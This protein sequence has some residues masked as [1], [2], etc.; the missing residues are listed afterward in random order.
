MR[1][2]KNCFLLKNFMIKILKK[3]F[4]KKFFTFHSKVI[5]LFCGISRCSVPSHIKMLY[6]EQYY[7]DYPQHQDQFF[8]F[9]SNTQ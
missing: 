6:G 2:L 7:P 9:L 5:R 8:S 3:F 4:V 1:E